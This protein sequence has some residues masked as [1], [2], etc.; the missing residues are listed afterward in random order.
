[1]GRNGTYE[2]SLPLVLLIS[3]LDKLCCLLEFG[4]HQLLLE[5]LVLEHF[6]NVLWEKQSGAHHSGVQGETP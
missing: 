1:M 2:L 3:I 4:V 6:V 5:F